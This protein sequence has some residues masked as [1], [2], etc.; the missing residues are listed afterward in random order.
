MSGQSFITTMLSADDADVRR[1]AAEDLLSSNRAEGTVIDA[2]STAAFVKGLTDPDKGVR[3][4]CALALT[5]GDESSIKQRAA[6]VVPLITHEDIE[7]RNLAGD[8]LLKLGSSAA[9]VLYP[10]LSDPKAD[11][12]KFACDIVA[13][14]N[15]KE[16]IP[17][18]RA[19][20]TDS[21]ENVRCAAIESLGFLKASDMLGDIVGMYDD[22]AVRPYVIAAIGHIGGKQ[23]QEFLLGLVS[24]DDAFIQI[25]AIDALAVSA[26]DIGISHTLLSMLPS[27]HRDI[28]PVILRTV[29][30]IAF[31]L[32]VSVELPDS[33][34]EVA[35]AALM[36]DEADTRIAGLLALGRVYE[37]ED[38]PVLLQ[39]MRN[40]NADTQQHIL[41]IILTSSAP[42]VAREFFD[43]VFECLVEGSSQITE[44]LGFLSILLPTAQA[45]NAAIAIQ[46]VM[47][48][49]PSLLHDQRREIIEFL[50]GVSRETV[51]NLLSDEILSGKANRID[52]AKQYAV[53]YNIDIREFADGQVEP[54]P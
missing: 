26:D 8:I 31:R 43:H 42:A 52:D 25:A 46:S 36:D 50:L 18:V 40:K 22:E 2:D 17:Y 1:R 19:L 15:N 27:S 30:S 16:A 12:R 10:Y 23:A 53:L 5:R 24:N 37:E 9:T 41:S 21:D 29:Y 13:L 33:L 39:E 35:H 28:Q 20:L 6:A 14:S 44:F 3:D 7:I 47:R 4:I 54:T 34:R 51:V 49:Y 38:V 11:N 32:Q 48:Q 45:E